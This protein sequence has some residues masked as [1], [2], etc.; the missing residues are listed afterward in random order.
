[1]LSHAYPAVLGQ[2]Q[3]ESG[4]VRESGLTPVQSPEKPG[5]VLIVDDSTPA[6]TCIRAIL[7]PFGW[8]FEEAADG[9]AAFTCLLD[10]HFDL[11]ITDLQMSPVS[12][13]DLLLAVQLLP[14]DHKPRTIICSA[15]HDS[16]AVDVVRAIRHADGVVAKPIVPAV[17]AAAAL[18]LFDRR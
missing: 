15:D 18:Q 5:S 12:G 4:Y 8:K 6:R 11:L 10:R 1:M 9:A 17:L 13:A 2:P 14:A 16:K 7:S 3:D